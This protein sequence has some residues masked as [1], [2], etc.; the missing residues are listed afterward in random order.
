M[1][2]LIVYLLVLH[3]PNQDNVRPTALRGVSRHVGQDSN[4]FTKC[5]PAC[6]ARTREH[7]NS[8]PE[9]TNPSVVVRVT[10]A[11]RGCRWSQSPAV[12]GAW[13]WILTRT[14]ALVPV[15]AR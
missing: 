15:G 10:L 12:P 2:L 4:E 1:K 7:D 11:A 5:G 9:G 13:Q 6:Q 3:L 8:W 14:G